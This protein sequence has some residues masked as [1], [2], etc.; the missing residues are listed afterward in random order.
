[1]RILLV[2]GALC[3]TDTICMHREICRFHPD[4]ASAMGDVVRKAD[5]GDN[6]C[7]QKVAEAD[8]TG[9]SEE[10][11]KVSQVQCPA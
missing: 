9:H 5:K 2:D 11:P 7:T 4:V 3:R 1:M 6:V 8:F 10:Q